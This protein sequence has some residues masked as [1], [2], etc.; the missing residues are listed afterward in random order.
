MSSRKVQAT[1][2]QGDRAEIG[3]TSARPRRG[4]LRVFDVLVIVL[5]A[6]VLLAPTVDS[7]VRTDEARGPAP[8]LR[9]A[10]GKP[11]L[12]ATLPSLSAYPSAYE[13][14]FGDCLG[15]RDYALGAGNWLKYHLF[16]TVSAPLQ[17]VGRDGWIYYQGDMSMQTFRGVFPFAPGELQAWAT[18][19][20]TRRRALAEQGCAYVF[21]IAP[22]KETIYPEHLPAGIQRLGPT[23]LEQFYEYM[24]AHTSV[25]FLD[26]RP[27]LLAAKSGDVGTMDALYSPHGTHW[28]GRGSMVVHDEITRWAAQHFPGTR[29]RT[30]ADFEYL[31]V[32]WGADTFAIGLYLG[33]ILK[34]PDR[35]PVLR[36]GWIHQL[37]EKRDAP[38]RWRRTVTQGEN[39]L[40]HT[41]LFHDSFGPFVYDQ[42]AASISTLDTSE[43]EYRPERVEAGRTK[44]V[45][46]MFVERYL[47][48]HA[49]RVG[50]DERVGGKEGRFAAL[51]TRLYRIAPE[52]PGL[53]AQGGL[54]LSFPRT[55][56]RRTTRVTRTAARQG[57]ET[58][59]FEVPAGQTVMSRVV[60]H[61]EIP[62]S[63]EIMWRAPATEPR[64]NRTRRVI[65]GLSAG[66]NDIMAELPIPAGSTRAFLRPSE[67]GVTLDIDDFELRAGIEPH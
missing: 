38:P 61:T 41:L 28:T 18:E 19:L 4:L 12:V 39:L 11:K 33:G 55:R 34:Q 49:P 21:V 56:E 5:F 47:V 8:E 32:D 35:F 50:A 65:L 24:R 26:L 6:G 43:G 67:E 7:F 2:A 15:L 14:W 63:L 48:N 42:L 31:P 46:E 51:S 9:R 64:F 66:D 22:N 54:E 36:G 52:Q 37:T 58:P 23:R 29:P 3:G 25:E 1:P 57:L 17:L 16:G 30:S 60:V 20:E 53:E 44:L 45:V 62:A 27:A 13:S 10:A 40:P 59:A